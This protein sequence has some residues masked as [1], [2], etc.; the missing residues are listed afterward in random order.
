M[1]AIDVP[2]MLSELEK[3]LQ[4]AITDRPPYHAEVETVL[5]EFRE[6]AEQLAFEDLPGSYK[7]D[8]DEILW[9]K[10]HYVVFDLY[11]KRLAKMRPQIKTKPTESRKLNGHFVKFI[12]TSMFFYRTHVQRLISH[13]GVTELEP[14]VKRLHKEVIRSPR[15]PKVPDLKIRQLVYRSCHRTLVCLGDLSRYRE[16][17]SFGSDEKDW[18]P[19][20][21]YYFLAKQVLPGLGSPHN[22]LAVMAM[23]EGSV[24]SSAYHFYRAICVAQPFPTAQDNLKLAFRKFLKHGKVSKEEGCKKRDEVE[25]RKLLEPFL[26]WAAR[27]SAGKLDNDALEINILTEL[28]VAVTNAIVTTDILMKIVLINLSTF[29]VICKSSG[30]TLVPQTAWFN[31]AIMT[32]LLECLNKELGNDTKKP[33]E[34]TTTV[35]RVLYGLRV[36][37]AWLMVHAQE[38]MGA[39]DHKL[40]L[41][42]TDF[43]IA[44]ANTMSTI[45]SQFGN[46]DMENPDVLLREDIDLIGYL[47]L[48]TGFHGI[49]S[50]AEQMALSEIEDATSKL[51]P[52]EETVVRIMDLLTDAVSLSAKDD[53]PLVFEDDEFTI[54]IPLVSST[55]AGFGPVPAPDFSSQSFFNTAEI[56]QPVESESHRMNAM[57]DSLVLDDD[58]EELLKPAAVKSPTPVFS[59]WDKTPVAIPGDGTNAARF[60]L[61]TT[62]TATANAFTPMSRDSYIMPGQI[63]PD[64]PYNTAR[65]DPFAPRTESPAV[66]GNGAPNAFS[67]FS[68]SKDKNVPSPLSPTQ[69]S[70]LL[71]SSQIPTV[72][73]AAAAAPMAA[74]RHQ[75]IPFFPPQ[76][77]MT[78][79]SAKRT[80]ISPIGSRTG[81]PVKPGIQT[82]A[83][84]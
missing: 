52:N 28:R 19:A 78:K 31:V 59:P 41:Q 53:I 80:S 23:Y 84:D 44:Y 38:L 37:S 34:F 18:R 22:Q 65:F 73:S 8:L 46:L 32:C 67:P 74:Q 2:A 15:A 56:Q 48:K 77:R 47:P 55:P 17:H 24:L 43:W 50:K 75:G 20:T 33:E 51:Q 6:V 36:Y 11:R 49:R 68:P 40:G 14:I 71:G 70:L 81:S 83:K 5:A 82:P 79:P 62:P 16:M 26:T 69:P 13:F 66:F 1:A 72:V 61:S 9:M 63:P 42:L 12:K 35:R 54:N 58:G 76:V 25:N 4:I 27:V 64:R 3:K 10:A 57:V 45:A 60:P 21:N 39:Q 30:L 7:A 29:Y